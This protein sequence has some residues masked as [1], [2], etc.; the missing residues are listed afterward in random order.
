MKLLKL[1]NGT[2]VNVSNFDGCEIDYTGKYQTPPVLSVEFTTGEGTYYYH[3]PHIT[4]ESYDKYEARALKVL[5]D[6]VTKVMELTG[7]SFEDTK[8]I[9]APIG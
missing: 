3:V 8:T 2:V 7:T 9:E 5:D 1:P 4:S 6:V